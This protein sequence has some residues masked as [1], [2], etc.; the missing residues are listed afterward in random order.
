MP[1]PRSCVVKTAMEPVRRNHCQIRRAKAELA[2]GYSAVMYQLKIAVYIFRTR[3][4][5]TT[6]KRWLNRRNNA[7]NTRNPIRRYV[8]CNNRLWTS[9]ITTWVQTA[10]K[11]QGLKSH[12]TT[13]QY[14]QLRRLT[15]SWRPINGLFFHRLGFSWDAKIHWGK[16]PI[17]FIYLL[18][19][20]SM[21]ALVAFTSFSS[22]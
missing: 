13:I 9:P 6:T 8:S 15:T 20:H 16:V 4:G 11:I 5:G 10:F 7:E 3:T 2:D 17:L 19:F 14:R 12:S 1:T 22:F 18:L 21:L